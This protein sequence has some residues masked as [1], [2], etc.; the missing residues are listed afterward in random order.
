MSTSAHTSLCTAKVKRPTEGRRFLPEELSHEA[1]TSHLFSGFPQNSGIFLLKILCIKSE[2]KS[3]FHLI[4][5]HTLPTHSGSSAAV[6]R[7]FPPPRQRQSTGG[8]CEA[9]YEKLHE[10]Q[11]QLTA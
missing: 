11:Q 8:G 2:L 4:S 7:S 10:Q 1:L 3:N 9:A 5:F 6:I